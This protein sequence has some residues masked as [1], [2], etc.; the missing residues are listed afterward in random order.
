[1][2]KIILPA[3]FLILLLA[4]FLPRFFIKVKIDCRTQY[5]GCPGEVI[6]QIIPFE[7]KN[8]FYANRELKK[9]LKSNFIISAFSVQFKLPNILRV[10]LIIKKPIFALRSV[11]AGTLALV[12]KE[13]MILA[14]SEETILPEVSVNGELPGPG[15]RV[16]DTH[17]L[18]LE[19]MQGVYKM[20]Q[21]RTS[22]IEGDTL[23]VELPGSIRVIFP[24]VDAD[25]EMLL[26]SL[27]LIYSGIKS[28]EGGA[29]YSQIDLRYKNPVLR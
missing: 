27:R 24:L 9:K 3:T 20:Y 1:M 13:G 11:T 19:L 14:L 12:D 5:G 26:G 18:A 22:T 16:A 15:E 25:R 23:L 21:T 29:L 28:G 17:L 8:M 6:D 4:I 2:K 10:D 7:G